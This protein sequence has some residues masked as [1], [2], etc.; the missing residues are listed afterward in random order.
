MNPPIQYMTIVE[1]VREVTWQGRTDFAPVQA[2]LASES[3]HPIPLD[4]QAHWLI[5]A[6]DTSYKG[7]RFQE[8]SFSVAVEPTHPKRS[9]PDYFLVH[10]FNSRGWFAWVERVFFGCPY[11]PAETHFDHSSLRVVR[12]GMPLWEVSMNSEQQVQ[13]AYQVWE[14]EIHLP[15]VHNRS[16][17]GSAFFY[18]RLE[19]N[20]TEHLGMTNIQYPELTDP[21]FSL[22]K[23]SHLTITRWHER[24]QGSHRKSQTYSHPN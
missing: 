19:G 4:G 3:C 9:I 10:A 21:F 7:I 13:T 24:P 17:K 16:R 12:E 18:A 15:K 20:A 6:V 14:G 22:L 11:Y 2:F 1:P 8:L 23:T 5:S